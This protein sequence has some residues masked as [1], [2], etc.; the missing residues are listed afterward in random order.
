[1]IGSTNG[2]PQIKRETKSVTT[3]SGGNFYLAE[4]SKNI[5]NVLVTGV[6]AE[7]FVRIHTYGTSIYGRLFDGAG[8]VLTNVTVNIAV[9]SAN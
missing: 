6:T 9:I 4:T 2:I 5:L 8:N 7:R 3:D 1:M